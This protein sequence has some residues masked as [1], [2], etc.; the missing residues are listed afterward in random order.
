M[1]HTNTE[2]YSDSLYQNIFWLFLM[3][4][5]QNLNHAV[6]F[7][8]FLDGEL[9][10]WCLLTIDEVTYSILSKDGQ[11]FCSLWQVKFIRNLSKWTKISPMRSIE[12]AWNLYSLHITNFTFSYFFKSSY[13]LL[14]VT[15]L[16][17]QCGI[18]LTANYV[19]K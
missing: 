2:P 12:W 8:C 18:Y 1:R 11:N 7:I 5:L 17:S 14:S 15:H 10:N 13:S 9:N 4:Y 16:R 19:Q 6:G 3:L